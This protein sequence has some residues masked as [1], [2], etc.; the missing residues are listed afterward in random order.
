MKKFMYAGFTTLLLALILAGC[1][2]EAEENRPDLTGTVNIAGNPW[3]GET[4]T[5]DTFAL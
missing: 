1:P 4:L 5:A 3:V 2:T